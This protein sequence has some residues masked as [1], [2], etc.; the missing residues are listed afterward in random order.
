MPTGRLGVLHEV[1]DA[2]RADLR[3]DPRLRYVLLLAL[4][5][6]GFWF[7]WRSPNFATADEYGRLLRPMKAGGEF[8]ADPSPSSFVRGATDGVPQGASF[9]LYAVTLVPAAL[10]VL[11]TGRLDEFGSFAGF[12]SRWDLWHAVPEWYWEASVLAARFANVLIAVAAVYVVYRIGTAAWDR[13]TG[14][15]GAL[16]LSLV[17]AFVASAHEI[18]EDTTMVLALLVTTYLALRFAQS[19]TRRYAY[20]GALAGGLAIGF[21]LTAGTAVFVLL[22][23]L[24]VRAGTE[25]DTG[26]RGVLQWAIDRPRLIAT[27]AAIG[28]VTIYVSRPHVLLEGPQAI[29]FRASWATSYSS[30][31]G[32]TSPPG[33]AP[34]R[35]LL[36]AAGLPLS[37]GAICAVGWHAAR[38]LRGRTESLLPSVL[39][40]GV[41]VYVLVFGSWTHIKAHHILPAVVLGVVLLAR[42]LARMGRPDGGR[43]ARIAAAVLLVTATLFAGAGT[44]SFATDPR[45]GAAGWIDDNVGENET[46]LVYEN[47]VADV[48]IVHGQ[49]V[50]HYDFVEEVGVSGSVANDTAFTDWIVSSPEREPEYVMVTA[51]GTSY[52]DAIGDA[53][54]RY[55]RRA[56]FFE[57]LID[58]DRFGY[59]VAAEFGDR[60]TDRSRASDLLRAGVVPEVEKRE[61]YVLL[62]RHPSVPEAGGR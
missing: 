20:W 29:L 8:V 17:L 19:G 26:W 10:V 2:F 15:Y 32:S 16:A 31:A 27:M 5:L 49:P 1:A 25:S 41:A 56:E 42:P 37:V 50:E 34:A 3:E 12:E 62:L 43:G 47:S 6:T 39:L 53:A 11:L 46:L 13:D 59:E 21:K 38:F 45:D 55:P 60:P 22:A 58:G 44:V 40:P 23:A 9:Y 54:D 30:A 48:G 18:D 36:S 4:L 57:R 14:F 35:A 52:A 28:A 51:A 24:V 7:W 33:F 61:P